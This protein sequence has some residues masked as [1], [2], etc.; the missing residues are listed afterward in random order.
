MSESYVLTPGMDRP[1]MVHKTPMDPERCPIEEVLHVPVTY[2]RAHAMLRS[3]EA[4]ACRRCGVRDLSIPGD[5]PTLAP[6][7]PG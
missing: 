3:G 2:Q 5:I 4:I 7:E 1:D 6:Q